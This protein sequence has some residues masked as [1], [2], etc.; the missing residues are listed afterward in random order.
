MRTAMTAAKATNVVEIVLMLPEPMY[1]TVGLGVPVAP[2][3]LLPARDVATVDGAGA[4]PPGRKY[5][6]RV[7]GA[8]TDVMTTVEFVPGTTEIGTVLLSSE[9]DPG[10][11]GQ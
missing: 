3:V 4:V 1:M 9:V 8:G 2:T 7:V 11:P 10:H 6:P 5:N